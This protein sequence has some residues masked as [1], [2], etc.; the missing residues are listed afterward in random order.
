MYPVPNG[1]ALIFKLVLTYA[2]ERKEFQQAQTRCTASQS[3]CQE[4]V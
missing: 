3:G 4:G 2:R 1:E